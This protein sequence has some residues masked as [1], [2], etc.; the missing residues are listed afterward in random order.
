MVSYLSHLLSQVE[1]LGLGPGGE[2]SLIDQD[3]TMCSHIWALG[4]EA[5]PV[6]DS[7]FPVALPHMTAEPLD[8]AFPPATSTCR[9]RTR[10]YQLGSKRSPR[11]EL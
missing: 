8:K 7:H 10:S 2:S 11:W 4:A 1:R 9:L 3:P 6:A 5:K